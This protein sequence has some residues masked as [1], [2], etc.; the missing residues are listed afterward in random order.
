MRLGDMH[1][2]YTSNRDAMLGVIKNFGQLNID[3]ATKVVEA[4]T[5][6]SFLFSIHSDTR[7]YHASRRSFIHCSEQLFHVRSFHIPSPT[8]LSW[9]SCYNLV[10]S[11]VIYLYESSPTG[12]SCSANCPSAA[13]AAGTTETAPPT[14][15]IRPTTTT[16]PA[17]FDGATAKLWHQRVGG[18][19]TQSPVCPFE[20]REWAQ[21]SK[22]ATP[23]R[24][25]AISSAIPPPSPAADGQ[26]A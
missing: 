14:A 16:S 15:T 2:G 12:T 17:T 5:P 9:G 7:C 25:T 4:L 13:T 10:C 21:H 6:L 26:P 18:E 19:D 8:H 11:S 3:G 23:S 20:R 24:A 22:S 1:I